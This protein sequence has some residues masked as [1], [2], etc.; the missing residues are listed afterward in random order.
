[1]VSSVDGEELYKDVLDMYYYKIKNQNW[2]DNDEVS[3]LF[4]NPYTNL[5]SLNN[6][7]YALIDIDGNGEFRDCKI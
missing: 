4:S 2:T 5:K 3:P 7:G 1:M 6:V